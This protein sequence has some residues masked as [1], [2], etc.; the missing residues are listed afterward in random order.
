MILDIYAY[1]RDKSLM[2]DV[3]ARE[4]T[5][6]D[7]QAG[8]D[9]VRKQVYHI[10]FFTKSYNGVPLLLQLYGRNCVCFMPISLFGEILY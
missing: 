4:I 2:I 10:N 8:I 9:T 3:Q 6:R 7:L 1:S 5:E